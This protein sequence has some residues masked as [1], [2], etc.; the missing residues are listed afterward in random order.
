MPFVFALLFD[1]RL[2]HAIDFASLSLVSAI[3]G[4]ELVKDSKKFLSQLVSIELLENGKELEL[5]KKISKKQVRLE[6]EK[7]LSF[8]LHKEQKYLKWG[9]NGPR[10]VLN[11]G[12]FRD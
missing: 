8:D 6:I 2:N 12:S 9:Q 5:V 7:I 3:W 1:L 4:R 10:N 11:L